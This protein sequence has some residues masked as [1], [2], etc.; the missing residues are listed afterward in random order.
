MGKRIALLDFIEV[1]GHDLS[2]FFRQIGFTSEHNRVD[3]SGFSASGN[4]EFL[5]GNTEQ[6]VTGEVFGGYAT[7]QT[8]DILY[9]IH[10]DRSIV[11]F[12]W[13]TDQVAGVSATNPQLEGNVQLL[14]WAGGATR[15]EVEAFPVT[16]SAADEAGLAYVET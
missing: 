11:T 1:D 13:R 4:D 10:R 2:N 9:P 14:S 3:V 15:G 7:N 16:F 8:Y 6:S 12:K 5:A